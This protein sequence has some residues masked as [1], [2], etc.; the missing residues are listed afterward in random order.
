MS[1]ERFNH[2]D[3]S[4]TALRSD[5]DTLKTD[6]AELK[7]GVAGLKVDVDRRF[8]DLRGEMLMLH[9]EVVDRI[10]AIPDPAERLERAMRAEFALFREEIGRRLDPL[11]AAVRLHF[12]SAP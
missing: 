6:V 9:E 12:R 3:Q 2:I 11:E 4:L 5:V 10:K 7:T 8:D 1:E